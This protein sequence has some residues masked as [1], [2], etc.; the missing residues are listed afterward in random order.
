[1]ASTAGK[2]LR[3]KEKNRRQCPVVLVP[4]FFLLT[5]VFAFRYLFIQDQGTDLTLWPLAFGG[6]WAVILS[7]MLVLWPRKVSRI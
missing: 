4:L 6:L 3:R 5:E 1:M 2:Y 7:G